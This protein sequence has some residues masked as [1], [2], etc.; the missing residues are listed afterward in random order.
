MTRTLTLL[1]LVAGTMLMAAATPA[2]PAGKE[3]PV[4]LPV[5]NDPTVSF[6]I[7]FKAGSQNDPAGKEGLAAITAEMLADASTKNNSYEAILDK[8]FPLAADYSASTSVEMTVI[9]GRSHRDNLGAYYPLLLDAILRP[10]FKQEDLER[11][12]SQALNSV[13]NTLRYANDEELGKA[14]LYG[15]IF[16]G[17]P[18]GHLQTGTI[19]SLKGITIDDVKA[20]YRKHYTR[21]NVV[22]GLGG[23]YDEA[24]LA[25]LQ[26]DLATLPAGKPA[27]AAAPVPAKLAGMK[28]TIVDK[29]AASTAISMGFPI[30]VLRG[31]REWYALA[32]ANSWLGEHR[33]SSSHLYKVIRETRGLNYGDYSYIENFPNGGSRQMPSQNVAR[34]KQIFE[35]WIRPVPNETRHFALRA[36][37]REFKTL[38]EKGMSEQD[39]QLTRGFLRK[40]VLHYAPT[41]SARLGYAL[42]DRFYGIQGSHLE[43]F[44]TM[45]GEITREEVNAA[46]RKHWQ[47]GAMQI[48]V[49]TRDAAAFKEALVANAASPITYSSPKPESVLAEDKEIAAFP[50]PI[51]AEHV[52]IVPV[53]EMFVK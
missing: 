15:E 8:M 44:R 4:L 29:D 51:K 33:N 31:S 52:T 7:W 23:G 38:V 49:V 24:L 32:I 48:A 12:R 53:T 3:S 47:Y 10:A 19:A 18:Y 1:L 17:T 42:D 50:L 46:I 21:E 5:A 26:A 45:M 16:R 14:V 35:I 40:Y 28:V 34:R 25:R 13:E 30:D 2:A 20:F 43:K 41:T 6:R 22:V 11:I 37:L 9:S 39:F 36:A 27:A